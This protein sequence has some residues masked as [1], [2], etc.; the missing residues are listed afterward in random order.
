MSRT[1]SIKRKM[2]NE[3]KGKKVA[4]ERKIKF[5]YDVK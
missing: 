1:D 2:F 3:K 5:V 4:R